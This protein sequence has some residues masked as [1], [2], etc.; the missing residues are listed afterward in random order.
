M[1]P[2]WRDTFVS[3][4]ADK[5]K[6]ILT[7]QPREKANRYSNG[8]HQRLRPRIG[9]AISQYLLLAQIHQLSR[10]I[11]LL[12]SATLRRNDTSLPLHRNQKQQHKHDEKTNQNSDNDR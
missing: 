3:S 2:V 12:L 9:A 7:K 4:K 1:T 11:R 5:N 8:N 10:K 6:L